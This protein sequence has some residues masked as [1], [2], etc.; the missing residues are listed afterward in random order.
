[1]NIRAL[2]LAAAAAAPFTAIGIDVLTPATF[3]HTM[4]VGETVTIQ[5]SLFVDNEAPT[6]ADLDVVFLMDETGSMGSVISDAKA[7]AADILSGLSGFGNV[8]FAVAGYQDSGDYSTPNPNGNDYFDWKTTPGALTSNT[9]TVQT[10]INSYG[11]FFGGDTPEAQIPSLWKVANETNWR[12][13]STRAVVWFGDAPGHNP[14]PDA[15]PASPSGDSVSLADAV[16]A[17]QANNVTVHGLSYPAGGGLDDTGQATTITNATGGTLRDGLGTPAG[18]TSD[19]LAAVGAT[20]DEYE[21]VT[22]DLSEVPVGLSAVLNPTEY[23]GDFDRSIERT[24]DFDLTFEG[25]APGEYEFTIYGLVD[26]GRVALETDRIIV[27]AIPEPSTVIAIVSLLLIAG[28]TGRS[29]LSRR[30]K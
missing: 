4:M 29:V 17:L 2:L 10:A 9:T 27:T 11:A 24:F 1:M 3:E 30:R 12:T 23:E 26:G 22:L 6:T 5:K 19:I 21:E 7:A 15:S 13:N 18:V 14:G 8:Q 20:F 25:L 28:V 16:A